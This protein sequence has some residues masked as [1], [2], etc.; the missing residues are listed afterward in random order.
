MVRG[1][2]FRDLNNNGVFDGSDLPYRNILV[3]TKKSNSNQSVTAVS[4]AGIYNNEVDTGQYTTSSN[5]NRPYYTVTPATATSTFSGFD[6]ADTVNFIVAPIPGLRD[7]YLNLS[8]QQILR[9]GRQL[10]YQLVYGNKGTDT[11]SNRT[12]SFVKD[13]KFE[14]ISSSPSPS[15]ISGDTLRWTVASFL[16]DSQR[17]IAMTLRIP[18]I[19]PMPAFWGYASLV[20]VYR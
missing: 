18:G 17:V 9:V 3:T 19:P 12:I 2:V 6:K 13:N 15:S 10:S 8:S 7:Y 14:F 1:N 16:P 20:W 11:L 5:F 4:S